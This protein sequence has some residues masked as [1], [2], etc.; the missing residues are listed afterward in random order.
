MSQGY[1]ATTWRQFTFD[2]SPQEFLVLNL[3]TSEGWK[4]ESTL[5]PSSGFDLGAHLINLRNMRDLVDHGDNWWFA[6]QNP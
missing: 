4:A 6:T 2:Q 1:R 3:S 5:E